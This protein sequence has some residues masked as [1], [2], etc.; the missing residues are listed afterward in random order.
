MRGTC[1]FKFIWALPSGRV[2][3]CEK[4]VKVFKVFKDFKVVIRVVVGRVGCSC[5]G[6]PKKRPKNLDG[7]KK[8]ITFAHRFGKPG[9][10]G[11]CSS[12]G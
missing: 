12:A 3:G 8:R 4:D 11:G 10:N 9:L 6:F 2:F 1:F 7:N 5:V